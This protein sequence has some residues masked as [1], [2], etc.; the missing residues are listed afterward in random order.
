MQVIGR[1]AGRSAIA[2]AAYRS[3]ERVKDKRT[4]TVHDYT[5]KKDI[6]DSEILKPEEAPERLGD[7]VTLWNEVEQNEKRKDSQ[8]CNE[9]MIA[10]PA[11]LSHRQKQEL[12]REYVQDE[13]VSQGMIADIGYHDFN[14]HNPHAHIMLT[15]RPVNEEG[16]GRKARKWNKRDA[17]RAYRADWANYANQALEQAGYEARI[18]HRSLKEQGIER[19]PQIHL[20]A[21]VMEMEARG[22]QTRVGDESRR[23]SA[24]NLD[25]ERQAAEQE[26]L[27]VEIAAEQ[28]SERSLL[29]PEVS[30]ASNTES[31]LSQLHDLDST[32]S[33]AH[34]QKPG[35][36]DDLVAA[37]TK[38][39]KA[40]VL[41]E[42]PVMD[43]LSSTLAAISETTK[44]LSAKTADMQDSID[45][46]LSCAEIDT[47]QKPVPVT[48][49]KQEPV[50]R[51][52]PSKQRQKKQAKK[53]DQGME[54]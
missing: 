23:I 2:A 20:G 30:A 49:K 33:L 3:G 36:V 34:L 5:R 7:R 22:I 14:S 1:S 53:R 44:K 4:G 51:Q 8:L 37:I 50:Q 54:L 29:Q 40:K 46:R 16:F 38:H 17:I 35:W 12:I 43:E 15:M 48:E 19:E 21:K 39:R 42:S 6:Y 27:Q 10:L 9:I 45:E 47:A 13:F 11:E 52:E 26:K 18:D 24:M 41:S 31:D 28:L 32:D 25:R